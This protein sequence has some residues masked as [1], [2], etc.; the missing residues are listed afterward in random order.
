M[1][2]PVQTIQ[3]FDALRRVR[4]GVQQ[5]CEI[6]TG[7]FGQQVGEADKT[8]KHAMAVETIGEIG[9]PRT[10][11]QITLVPISARIRV[12]QQPQP[13]AIES[14]IGGRSGLAEKLPEIRVAGEGTKPRKLEL[15]QRKVSFIEVDRID[16]RRSRGKIRQRIASARRNG[17]DSRADRQPKRGKIGFRV[18][19]NL[20]VDQAA[21]PEREKPVP[22]SR[23]VV[24]PAVAD[25]VRDKLRVHPSPESA[26]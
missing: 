10:P 16:L 22:N 2:Q 25:R 11:D 3:R 12:E 14:G 5:R 9:M 21:K 7:E 1:E 6:D 26:I 13:F 17:D 8:A 19:P 24:T 23:F 20:G 4:L 18:L 15:E